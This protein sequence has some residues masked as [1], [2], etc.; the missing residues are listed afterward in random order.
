MSPSLS[1][2]GDVTQR[3]SADSTR[4]QMTTHGAA[5]GPPGDR[6]AGRE[7]RT[8]GA[9]LAGEEVG[10]DGHDQVTQTED[11]SPGLRAGSESPLLHP[12]AFCT[13]SCQK[14]FRHSTHPARGESGPEMVDVG[15]AWAGPS[16]LCGNLRECS[17]LHCP[18]TQTGLVGSPPTQKGWPYRG[19]RK[20]PQALLQKRRQPSHTVT[21]QKGHESPRGAGTLPVVSA[22][23]S[24]ADVE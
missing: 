13:Q 4:L 22:P 21:A 14:Y 17:I 11:Q 24:T 8:A 20:A 16:S 1:S 23:E 7:V 3:I 12:V 19:Q 10:S 18:L 5:K 15:R 2:H 6:E 9:C